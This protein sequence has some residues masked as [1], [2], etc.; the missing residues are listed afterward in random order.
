MIQCPKCNNNIEI[1]K[2]FFGGVVD[3]L[4]CKEK[5]IIPLNLTSGLNIENYRLEEFIA[6]GGTAEVWLASN[7][8]TGKTVAIKLID[9]TLT[10]D[11]KILHRFQSELNLTSKL[12]H[13]NIISTLNAGVISGVCY[14]VME[15]I[16]GEELDFIIEEANRLPE[17]E[18]LEICLKVVSGLEYAWKNLKVLHRDIKPSNIMLA[19]GATIKIMDMGIAKSSLQTRGITTLG[20]AVGTP[21]YMSPEHLL[22]KEE[23]DFRTDIYSLGATLYLMLTGEKVFDAEN[24]MEVAKKVLKENFKSPKKIIPEL[25]DNVTE[26]LNIM[27]A[28]NKEDRQESYGDLKKDISDVLDGKPPTSKNKDEKVSAHDRHT[29]AMQAIS[30]DERYIKKHDNKIRLKDILIA[31]GI[32]IILILIALYFVM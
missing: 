12:K 1:D 18:S 20:E 11:E 25:S 28:K 31:G 15:Y 7:L 26:L 4:E 32:F 21:C 3:C 27:L 17:K 16:E 22:G 8:T 5:N 6:K 9:P 23:L 30:E 2:S 29:V 10:K 24:P 14:L 13:K 19:E